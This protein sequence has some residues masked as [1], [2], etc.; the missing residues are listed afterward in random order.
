MQ[1]RAPNRNAMKNYHYWIKKPSHWAAA[2]LA[3]SIT[4]ALSYVANTRINKGKNGNF[5]DH[6]LIIL[7]NLEF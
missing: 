1:E 6:W 5:F 3:R 2:I 7:R 4:I